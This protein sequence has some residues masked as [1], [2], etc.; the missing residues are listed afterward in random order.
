MDITGLGPI[1]AGLAA[2]GVIG[3][4]IGIGILTGLA[5]TAIGRNPDATPQIRAQFIL[6]A[7]FAEGLGVLAI[8]VAHPRPR[9]LR[10]RG[11]SHRGPARDRERGRPRLVRARRGGAVGSPDQPV[12]GHRLRAEL[13]LLR[14]DPV[15]AVRRAADA[16]ADERRQRVEQGLADAEQARSDRE[17]AESERLATLQEARREANDIL[18]RAQKVA[19]DSRDADIAATKA[20][21]ERL[22]ERATAEIDAEKQRAISEL[23]GE[24]ADLALAAASRVVGETI[25]HRP[26]AAPRRGVPRRDRQP[27]ARRIGRLARRRRGQLMARRDTAPRRYADAAFEIGLRDGTVEVWRR[28]LDA[29]AATAADVR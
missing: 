7:A 10:A 18:T 22:R 12:L 6:G 27:S 13:R 19:Q 29:A 16:D 26:R 5:A 28:E 24:V 25:E 8:V 20:E 11:G 4:G 1:G 15:L 14:G 9:P 17:S 3:P 21:L 2:L 23:R